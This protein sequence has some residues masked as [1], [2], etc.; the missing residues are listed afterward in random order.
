[1]L[2][3][4]VVAMLK[5]ACNASPKNEFSGTYANHS[6][7]E[8]SIADDTL[9]LVQLSDVEYQIVRRTGFNLIRNGKVGSRQHETENWRLS[10]EATQQLLR[11]QF[12]GK[13]IRVVPDSGMLVIG[14]REYRKIKP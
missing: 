9:E 1:M 3:F 12:R 13:L 2:V 10:Y 8:Y 11:E 7:G 14:H 5:A 6:E 4:A